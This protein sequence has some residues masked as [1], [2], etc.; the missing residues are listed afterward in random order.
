MSSVSRFV[1]SSAGG[2]GMK[3][4][5]GFVVD[6]YESAPDDLNV[7][8]PD[9]PKNVILCRLTAEADELQSFVGKKTNKQ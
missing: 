9:W 5:M 8:L 1:R 4:L 3:W 6:C 7:R 2:V